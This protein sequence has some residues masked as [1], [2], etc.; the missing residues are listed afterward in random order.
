MTSSWSM[1]LQEL[2]MVVVSVNNFITQFV[3]NVLR[4]AQ[5]Q[6]LTWLVTGLLRTLLDIDFISHKTHSSAIVDSPQYCLHVHH[7]IICQHNRNES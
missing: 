7:L 5:S 3:K 2:A 4:S 6:T 1:S